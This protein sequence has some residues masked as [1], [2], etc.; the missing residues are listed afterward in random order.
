MTRSLPPRICLRYLSI[1]TALFW[2]EVVVTL[3]ALGN[4]P[5]LVKTLI[6][7]RL[8]YSDV[9]LACVRPLE[10]G[11]LGFYCPLDYWYSCLCVKYNP[12]GLRYERKPL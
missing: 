1:F 9:G 5:T 3:L 8:F 7:E 2:F 11:T 6:S 12:F 10:P 4:I